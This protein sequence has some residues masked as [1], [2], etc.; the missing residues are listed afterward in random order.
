MESELFDI[1]IVYTEKLATSASTLKNGVVLPFAKGSNSESYN[2]VYG[3]FLEICQKNG[4]KAAFTTSAGVIGAGKCKSY[5]LFDK[6]KWIK[7][8]KAG[9]SKLIFDKFSPVNKRIKDSRDLLFSSEK[10]KPFNSPYL[11]DLFFDKY[12]TYKKL[13]QFSIPTV[14][15]KKN[16][17]KSV[18][19]A[20]KT[21]EQIKSNH[22]HREDFSDEIIMKDRFGAGGRSVFKFKKNNL[23]SIVR[24]VKKSSKTFILQPFIKFDKGFR[25]HD[26]FSPTDIRLI[27]LGGKIIQTYIRIAKRGGFRC[28]E[29]RGGCLIYVSKRE[30]PQG[31]TNLSKE[32]TKVLGNDSSLY[33]LDFIISNNKNIYF[34][35]GNT[36]PGLDWNTSSKVNEI[37]AKKLIRIIVKELV[38]RSASKNI[39]KKAYR[40]EVDS[41]VPATVTTIPPEPAFV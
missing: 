41:P 23:K 27:F 36:G 1:L 26:S 17:L 12:E 5:W 39:S 35:E 21:L 11:F 13:H 14:S 3:F 38:K 10:V 29:H 2:I 33:S 34:L 8:K 31:I 25:Y 15:I 19:S 37:E 22:P 16:T 20:C 9:Y 30:I 18:K 6:S 40:S 7:V 28:N 32:I 4:L 24:I